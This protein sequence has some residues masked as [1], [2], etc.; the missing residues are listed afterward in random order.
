MVNKVFIVSYCVLNIIF[1]LEILPKFYEYYKKYGSVFKVRIGPIKHYVVFADAKSAE[2]ILNSSKYIDKSDD[3]E[4]FHPWLSTGLLTSTGEK[5]RKRRK[6]LTPTFHFSI[7]ER[8][9]DVFDK[10]GDKLVEKLKS[11]TGQAFDISPYVS[12]CSL[13]I[14]CGRFILVDIHKRFFVYVDCIFF[15]ISYGGNH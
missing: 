3:Y 12:L 7:L 6:L 13:D 5:W 11:T 10:A 15:R 2:C 14:V 4:L 9:V 8:F 1:V